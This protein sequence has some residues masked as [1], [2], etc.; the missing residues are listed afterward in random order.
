MQVSCPLPLSV[1]ASGH[2][3]RVLTHRD[4][5]TH[6]CVGEHGHHCFRQWLIVSSATSHRLKQCWLIVIELLIKRENYL[7]FDN[8]VRK[9]ATILWRA[10]ELIV[11]KNCLSLYSRHRGHWAGYQHT[12]I[13]TK[14]QP[15]GRQFT[16]IF[17]CVNYRISLKISLMFPIGNNA[18]LVEMK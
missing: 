5:V 8:I 16:I 14:R 13:E 11:I 6:I 17:F 18:A 1:R 4:W 7:Q 3:L 12:D 10:V 15:F 9:L 2:H